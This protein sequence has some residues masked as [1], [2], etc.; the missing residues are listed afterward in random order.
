MI[1]EHQESDNDDVVYA[2]N[3][4]ADQCICVGERSSH[5]QKH[6]S[7]HIVDQMRMN[8]STLELELKSKHCFDVIDLRNVP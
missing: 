3:T 6:A 1:F 7:I 2:K 4:Y 8:H 5:A